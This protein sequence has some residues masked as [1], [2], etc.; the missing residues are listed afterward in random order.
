MNLWLNIERIHHFYFSLWFFSPSSKMKVKNSKCWVV[1]YVGFAQNIPNRLSFPA[2][3]V[4][5]RWPFCR[6]QQ[7]FIGFWPVTTPK[8][9][10]KSLWILLTPLIHGSMPNLFK[11]PPVTQFP[12]SFWFYPTGLNGIT[13]KLNFGFWVHRPVPSQ[14]L[15]VSFS[16]EEHVEPTVQHSR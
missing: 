8:E 2:S 14:K 7:I 9:G 1:R 15:T 11:Y 16:S 5:G 12:S 3:L 10:N 6:P 4:P 13:L